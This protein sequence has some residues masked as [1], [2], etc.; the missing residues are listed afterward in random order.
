VQGFVAPNETL[1]NRDA[2]ISG[3]LPLNDL[4][5]PSWLHDGTFVAAAFSNLLKG[6]GIW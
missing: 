4:A 2:D 3:K 6:Y 1:S 5:W